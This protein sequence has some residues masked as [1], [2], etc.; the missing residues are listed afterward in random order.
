VTNVEYAGQ[1]YNDDRLFILHL[2]KCTIDGSAL[3]T[4]ATTIY[5][6]NAPGESK[7]CLAT[8]RN[9]ARYP[10]VRVDDFYSLEAARTY[11]ERVAPTGPLVSLGGQSPAEPLPYDQWLAWKTKNGFQDY[12]YKKRY[13]PGGKNP[14]EVVISKKR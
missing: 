11:M 2:C 12:D 8:F 13:L 1:T 9:T 10:A 3:E 14:R 5:H 6:E 4:I 7:W